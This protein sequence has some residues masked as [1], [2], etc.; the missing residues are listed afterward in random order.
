[1]KKWPAQ[2]SDTQKRRRNGEMAKICEMTAYHR[3]WLAKASQARRNSA[4]LILCNLFPLIQWRHGGVGIGGGMSS[5]KEA[6]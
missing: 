5:M 1:M 2:S 6:Q 3:L 4:K